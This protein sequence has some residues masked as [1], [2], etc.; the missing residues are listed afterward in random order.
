MPG[1]ARLT[2]FSNHKTDPL[3][4]QQNHM[5]YQ[6]AFSRDTSLS[7]NKCPSFFTTDCHGNGNNKTRVMQHALVVLD[8]EPNL[9]LSL[10]PTCC[11]GAQEHIQQPKRLQASKL[12]DNITIECFLHIK[13]YNNVVWYKQEMGMNLQAISK[14]YIYLSKV[15]FAD[16]YNDGRF[17][18]T[19]SRS[20]YHLHIFLTKKEDIATYFCGVISLGELNFG[21]GT[22]L[23]L[24]EEHTATTVFQ[25]PISDK[26]HIGDNITLMC[27]VQTPDEKCK[28]GHHVY[29]FREAADESGSGII[30]TDG[31][32]KKHE[33]IYHEQS[34]VST[35][36]CSKDIYFI[37]TLLF[38][39][40]IF[41]ICIVPLVLAII[42]EHRKQRHRKVAACQAQRHDDKSP[43]LLPHTLIAMK[44]NIMR[45]L[46][47]QC[48]PLYSS[49]NT[50][51]NT[52]KNPEEQPVI[53]RI[54]MLCI[55]LLDSPTAAQDFIASAA[56]IQ[57]KILETFTAGETIT[58]ECLISQEHG[59]YYSWFKQSL[60]EAPTCIL[61]VY[62]DSLTPIF[63][64]DFKN[65]KRFTVLK[66]EDLFALTIK[67]AKPSDTG[68]YFCDARDY[69][70]T[71]FSSGLFLN[72]KVDSG[73]LVNEHEFNPGDSVNLHCSVLTEKSV[74]NHSVYWFRHESG[75]TH[76]G[77][78][79]KHG[80]INDQCEK[81]SEK[82][83]HVQ[84]CVYNL[85]KKNLSLTNA[86]TY[87]CAVAICGE[88]LFGNGSTLE[89]GGCIEA[90][91][92][93]Q[94]KRL[95]AYKVGDNITVE[96][97]LHIKD[98]NNVVW[99]KQEM[100][101]N[102]Q[103][104]SKTYIYL[105]KVNFAV[106]YN[107][108][109]FNVTKNLSLTDAGTYYCAVAICGE[110]LFGNG[111]TLEI[112][113]CIGAQG[114]QQPKRLQASKLGDNITVECFLPKKDYNLIVWYKQEMGMNLQ[115]ISKS[116][117]YLTKEDIATYS[118]GVITLG[119]LTFG[120]GTFLM[121]HEQHTATTVF[122][123]PISD[124]V[125][126]GDNLTL[127][128]RVQTP[129]EKC[130]VG[131]HVYWFREAADES[132]SGI[133]YNDGDMKKHEE[134]CKDDSTS[135]TCI[136]TLTKRNLSLS[137]AGCIGAQG[138]Q[139][140]KRL[141]ASKL[142]DNITVECFLPKKDY[143]LIV[144]Y[145]QE[146]G[147]NLQ[148]ISKSYIYLTKEDIA[149]YS[150]GVI[151]LGELTFGPGTFLMLHEQHTATT[152]FQEP[153]SDKVHIGDNLTLMCRVQTPH[154]KCKVGHHVYWFREAADESGS[155]IIYNDGD[156]K[157][158]EEIC[159]DDSTSQT[160]IY[161]LTKRNLSLSD[162]GFLQ[163]L[164]SIA[165]IQAQP[166]Q[167][168]TMWCSHDIHVTG[169]LY[170]FK[171]T[172]EAVP[173]TIVRMLYTESLQKVEPKYYNSFT[174]D[175]MVMDQFNRN[176]T[177]TI[178][179]VKI[180]DS[181]FY[182]CGA[183][184][185]H[186]NF[187]SGTRLEV[188]DFIASAAVIQKKILETFTAGETITLE[189]LISQ[190]HGNYYSWFKQ[191][192]GEAPTCILSLYAVSLTPMFYGDFKND[193]RF[194]VLKQ[195]DLFAL[196]IND[197]KPS[198][199]G[200]YYCGARD[201]DLT[202]FSSGLF[203]N[204]KGCIGAQGIQQP[205]RLQ[206]SK[207]G[208]NITV[209]CFL[210]KKDYNL[211]VWYKQ[212]MGMNLQAISKSYIYLTKEDIATYSC[213]VITLGELTF[214]PGTFLMLHEQHTAT[215]VFQ[216]P[217]SDKVHIGDNLT[218]MCRV[219]TPHEKCKVGHH[220]YWFREAADESGSGIIY[221]DGDMKKHE[222][223]CKDDSTSQTC[224]YTLTKRN[225][226]LSDADLKKSPISTRD[227]SEN[228]FY[229]LT[230]IFGGI[231][232]ILIIIIPLTTLIIK[233]H[234]RNKQEKDFIASAAVVQKKA[235]E[236][237]TAG[238][239]ITL[240]CLIPQNYENYYSW[241]KQSL[242][243]APT[244]ILSLY[245]DTSTP[246]FYGNFKNDKR[247]TVLKQG[248]LFSL[249]INDAKPSDTGI[250]Y[251]GARDYDLITFS[252]GLFLNYKG[253]ET[254]QHHIKQFLSA[255]D[256]GTLVNEHAFKPGDSVNIHC[257]VLT[258]KYV[259]NHSI[260]WFT[261]ESGDTHPGIIYK[262]GN[263]ND[264]CEKSSEKD[265][266]VQSCV[267]NLPKK[268]LSLTDAGTYYCAVA[269]CGEILFGNGSTIEIGVNGTMVNDSYW[270]TVLKHLE[271]NVT[272]EKNGTKTSEKDHEK[273]PMSTEECSRNVYF[274]LT[275]LFG[276][277]IFCTYVI[278]FILAIIKKRRQKHKKET[279][280]VK[281]KEDN[282]REQ[283]FVFVL[284]TLVPITVVSMLLNIILYL[285]KTD[286]SKSQGHKLGIAID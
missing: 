214:G 170:W 59:N 110:I 253:G 70:L 65:D 155:G 201:Y 277:I 11:I 32:M 163:V 262:H 175:S 25:E 165:N 31:D 254:R 117:I 109:R 4:Q 72:Y 18:V 211:I 178:K 233:I 167:S 19:T 188:K 271:K 101:M 85:P 144:W 83:S 215:T 13:D 132:G 63:Y 138:I 41:L 86:G 60:G 150:C 222:E 80:N 131:H 281:E 136:Y 106:G 244:C 219:Q 102:L 257:S 197:A 166:G 151:T 47:H 274:I 264:Q 164:L 99:Y 217:I 207:L 22:F 190:E 26:V 24:H 189:C 194:T 135:Q 220:V 105:T 198:D 209:E 255:M 159:K 205:K 10:Q 96:C 16:G 93:Q 216:E 67:E 49:Q 179:E 273:S 141:Q 252:S 82:D 162:A 186:M 171:Q 5:V 126:I 206:A 134:I 6:A 68:I 235:L 208:D 107:D 239:T 114:I 54:Q 156:M 113:G 276:G 35:Q 129:H 145:K 193:K 137:D 64:G 133:I 74:G 34:S 20:I 9:L 218:L 97:F 196:T 73:T 284:P 263:I 250:Y 50:R 161:T 40:I 30:Y 38:G 267:Y 90:Q 256:S 230:F 169:D 58:L 192:L 234:N 275:L 168:V 249:T 152:V 143:N 221:N 224:I 43:F 120:P 241:F 51:K 142:G 183:T 269:T 147:M 236:T 237:F 210:P 204:Y 56:V 174:K 98:Y 278:P 103:A 2:M 185:Y 157:K 213:G 111:S 21:P 246:T 258:E 227:C 247:F 200:I 88:I 44:Y 15:D 184:G 261:H 180:S 148:A 248:D 181:G 36:E 238:E 226:S 124:K 3:S 231:I 279:V 130:K 27:R 87:Y 69:D 76:P 75:D 270:S 153:I 77:I 154:E 28:V 259:G 14:N 160:C 112:G 42:R 240:E 225:L 55:L 146:M 266:H 53:Q 122:Q 66:K 33:E 12:G 1:N 140:P 92:I 39:G 199:A 23:M 202:I 52:R 104:I 17:N 158:H 127:M 108:S 71:S 119:E 81:S 37:L 79:Y 57:K 203:L 182:F 173:I 123:E 268:N 121:L 89:I 187:G 149:T 78:I 46:I 177:L 232:V 172:D 243:E 115:A 7:F 223:I 242:G 272:S 245:A 228:I 229:K 84:S 118:C 128:C 195:R 251:C 29:W 285:Q 283:L 176:T 8:F 260:Y 61:S 125:H 212:E 191:S 282:W 280:L 94:P 100:G 139:Q 116:Y 286:T 45:S 91:G 48:M 265:S 95:Q 62:A